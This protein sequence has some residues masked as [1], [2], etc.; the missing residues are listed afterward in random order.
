MTR[1]T[2]PS[3]TLA[4]TALSRRSA[5]TPTDPLKRLMGGLT[6]VALLVA[7]LAATAVPARADKRSDNIAKLIV[8]ALIVGA[9]VNEMKDDKPKPPKHPPHSARIPAACAITIDSQERRNVTLYGGNCLRDHGIRNLPSCGRS[10]TI[11]GQRDRLYSA[12]C[13]RS[14]GYRT[15]YN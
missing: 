2:A 9:I 13:L 3:A 4:E 12:D 15:P 14:A 11:Y 8:G 7:L 5:A 10:M 6:V 1:H